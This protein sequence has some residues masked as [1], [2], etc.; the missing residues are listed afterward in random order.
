MTGLWAFRQLFTKTLKSERIAPEED[1]SLAQVIE[2]G[3]FKMD[4][5]RR[6]ATLR[7]QELQLTSEEFDVLVFLASHPQRLITPRTMLNTNWSGDRLHHTNV[8]RV[9][10]SLRAKLEAAGSGKHYLRTEP[11]L[12]YRFDPSSAA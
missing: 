2:S 3:D 6:V 8:L 9:L 7:E 4:L 11:W 5:C 1:V 12:L 10:L